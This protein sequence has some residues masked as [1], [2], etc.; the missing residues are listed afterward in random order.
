MGIPVGKL[1]LYTACA[2]VHPGYCLPITLDVGTDNASLHAGEAYIGLKEKQL[3][4]ESYNAFIEEFVEAVKQGFPRA[5]LQWEDFGN[6]NAFRL[7]GQYRRRLPSFND[8]I[9][10]AAAVA[11]AGLIWALRITRSTLAEQRLLFLG[12]GEAGTG[13]AD[14][15]VA[16]AK[17]A[18]IAEAWARCWFVDS[19]SRVVKDRSDPLAAHKLPYAHLRVPVATLAEAVAILRPTALIG[20]LGT[21]ATFT[22]EIVEAMAQLNARPMI[23]ALSN[24]TSKGECTAE[25]AYGWSRHLCQRQ[26]VSG[27][28]IKR[29]ALRAR[30]RQRYLYLPR[31]GA[32]RVGERG[33]RGHRRHFSRGGGDVGESGSTGGL[34]GRADLSAVDENPRG[35]AAD[36]RGCGLVRARRRP[37]QSAA[38]GGYRGGY[39]GPDV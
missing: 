10:G 19:K 14:L 22:R 6:T 9:Q 29:N 3:R 16:A 4:G 36:R 32:R 8:D 1:S 35:F 2:G 23:F 27:G 12:A 7:L 5:L 39:L 24:P 31:G 17:T 38:S 11:V 28:G 33:E 21:P 34:G 20:V 26:P 30:S 15:Y 18:G 25:K 37:V 13:S